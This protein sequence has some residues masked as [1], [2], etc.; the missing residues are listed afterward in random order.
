MSTISFSNGFSNGAFSNAGSKLSEKLGEKQ[1]KKSDE[2]IYQYQHNEPRIVIIGV[3][4]AGCN[5]INNIVS[6]GIEGVKLFVANTDNQS[7]GKSLCENKI[8]LG[9][10]ITNG[11]GA[12]SSPEIGEQAA[13]ESVKQIE[14]AVRGANMVFVTAGMGGGTGTGA[15]PVIANIARKMGILTIGVVTKPFKFERERRMN[16]ANEGII[17]MTNSTDTL[18]VI[19]NQN[20]FRI[21]NEQTTLTDAFSKVDDVLFSG[22]RCI[23]D[24]I[25]KAGLV[26]LDFADVASVMSHGGRSVMGEGE[27]E[28]DD[29]AVIS[30]EKAITNPIL[31]VSSVRGAKGILI[32]ITGGS[33]MT[34]FE[35]NDAIDRITQ[36]IDPNA[37]IKFGSI[38]EEGFEGKMRVSVVA[39][40]VDEQDIKNDLKSSKMDTEMFFVAKNSKKQE[41]SQANQPLQQNDLF[42]GVKVHGYQQNKGEQPK[43]YHQAYGSNGGFSSTQNYEEQKKVVQSRYSQGGGGSAGVGGSFNQNIQPSFYPQA[44]PKGDAQN[45]QHGNYNSHQRQS[46]ALQQTEDDDFDVQHNA[47]GFGAGQDEAKNPLANVQSISK[48]PAQNPSKNSARNSDGSAEGQFSRK[49]IITDESNSSEFADEFATASIEKA[50]SIFARFMKKK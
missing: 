48:N 8:Q 39:T 16:S 22:I 31:E 23:T 13:H 42:G 9:T 50:T 6:K 11:L 18:I 28:G 25:I 35:V 20:V 34:L 47:P 49:I 21:A 27:A 19:S 46:F 3:G 2:N 41:T 15:A 7:L 14:E 30:A 43:F 32:N 26:N 17:K 40:G 4:G 44:Y 37:I 10:N 38:I 45:I 29:R 36:E 1:A 5:A 12:G 24:L 33:D